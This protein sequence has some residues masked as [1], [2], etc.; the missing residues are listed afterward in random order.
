MGFVAI[1]YA[2]PQCKNIG[3]RS[4]FDKVTVIFTENLKV[5]TLFET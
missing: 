5:G 1:S 4:R 3:N 2:F